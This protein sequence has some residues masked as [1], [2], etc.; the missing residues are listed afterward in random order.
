[1]KNNKKCN[2]NDI[3]VTFGTIE[4]FDKHYLI[5][6]LFLLDKIKELQNEPEKAFYY[7]LPVIILS[8]T[9]LEA[10]INHL[11]YCINEQN[12]YKE[13]F[14]EI[15]RDFVGDLYKDFDI[16]KASILDK[17]Y[18]LLKYCKRENVKSRHEYELAKKVI[19]LRNLLVHIKPYSVNSNPETEDDKIVKKLMGEYEIENMPNTINNRWQNYLNYNG[20]CWVFHIVI[21]FFGYFWHQLLPTKTTPYYDLLAHILKKHPKPPKPKKYKHKIIKDTLIFQR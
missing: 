4:T 8:V 17:Y 7:T 10:F 20:A 14:Q 9:F 5:S 18:Y 15:E 3:I 19:E 11:Y 16:E 12:C 13:D 2:S 6:I 21:D 1:M